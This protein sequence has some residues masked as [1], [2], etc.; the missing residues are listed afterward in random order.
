[1]FDRA[2][3]DSPAVE[4]VYRSFW[5]GRPAWWTVSS[6]NRLSQPNLAEVLHTRGVPTVLVT[7]DVE[8]RT[9]P[10]A[11]AF[12]EAVHVPQIEAP[13]QAQEWTDTQLAAFFAAAAETL[14]QSRSPGMAWLHTGALGRVWDSPQ[15]LREQYAAEDDPPAPALVEPPSAVLAGDTDPDNL[16]GLHHAYA[17]EITVLDQ[18]LNML[19]AAIDDGPW[20][21]ALL[22]VT[23]ARGY[24]LGEHGFVGCSGEAL[25]G[26]LL[27]APCFIRRPGGLKY[28]RRSQT[29]VQPPDFY[30]TLLEWFAAGESAP[31]SASRSPF[32]A[33]SLLHVDENIESWRELAIARSPSGEIALATPAWFVRAPATGGFSPAQRSTLQ[34]ASEAATRQ[35]ELF[36][37]PDDHFEANEVSGRCLEIVDEFRNLLPSLNSACEQG[38]AFEFT[39]SRPLVEGIEAKSAR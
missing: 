34:F 18:G 6:T 17:G 10:L 23:S 21:D 38:V 2:K 4:Q 14:G 30:A 5:T 12:D 25:Y 13:H 32:A 28:G 29:L 36:V 19:L 3:I 39:P 24:P 7:D 26:E 27:S 11:T 8:I 31:Q 20:R 22:V 15:V 9:H 16:L 35:L 33:R 37:K 1:V